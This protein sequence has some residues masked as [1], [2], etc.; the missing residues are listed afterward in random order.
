MKTVWDPDTVARAAR[1]Q[2]RAREL[3]WGYRIGQHASKRVA[4]GIE[5]MDTKEYTPGDPIRDI[6][7]RVAARS[8]RL[9]I[10]RQ[11]AETDL[12]IFLVLDASAEVGVW[13]WRRP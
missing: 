9:V 8:D 7:W 6:D 3:A 4:K 2:L 12:K 1:I 13:R 5:F 10:R 11:V